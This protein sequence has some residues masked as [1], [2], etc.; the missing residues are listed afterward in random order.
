[1]Q[2]SHIVAFVLDATPIIYEE[3]RTRPKMI[4]I[5]ETDTIDLN[6]LGVVRFKRVNST[7]IPVYESVYL[8]YDDDIRPCGF[9][10][11]YQ[12]PVSEIDY[13]QQFNTDDYC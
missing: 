1:M 10:Y 2:T 12:G 13:E 4:P 3:R 7:H 11:L 5:Y 9:R 6:G 8:Q